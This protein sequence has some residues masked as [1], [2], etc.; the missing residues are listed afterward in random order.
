MG[1][2]AG[3]AHSVAVNTGAPFAFW[4]H[5]SSALLDHSI[6]SLLT[7]LPVPQ[8][9]PCAARRL[10]PLRQQ[11]LQRHPVQQATQRAPEGQSASRPS[12]NSDAAVAVAAAAGGTLLLSPAVHA[13]QQT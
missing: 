2:P 11:V 1:S 6:T 7:E 3:T 8:Q 5:Q 10:A 9:C 13:A 4:H 12:S